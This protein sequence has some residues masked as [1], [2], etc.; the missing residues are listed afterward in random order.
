MGAVFGVTELM[1][2]AKRHIAHIIEIRNAYIILVKNIKEEDKSE[3]VGVDGC[4]TLQ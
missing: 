3:S 1:T 2:L 4:I